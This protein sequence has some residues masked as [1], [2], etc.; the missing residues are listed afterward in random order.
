[1]QKQHDSS[2]TDV[3]LNLTTL[4][5]SKLRFFC[6]Y[7]TSILSKPMLFCYYTTSVSGKPMLLGVWQHQL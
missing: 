7:T 3:V 2:K 4:F 1:M 6:Y 5:L